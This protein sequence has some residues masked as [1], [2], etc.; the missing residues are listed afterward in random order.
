MKAI[1]TVQRRMSNA[2][3]LSCKS[4]CDVIENNSS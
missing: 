1:N 4:N 2:I 3:K